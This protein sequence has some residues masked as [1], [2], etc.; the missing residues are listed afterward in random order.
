M[1]NPEKATELVS[2]VLLKGEV[3][4]G[5]STGGPLENLS[6]QLW[7]REVLSL[8]QSSFLPFGIEPLITEL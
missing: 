1:Q 3:V 4:E 2:Q 8:V 6:E 5:P 7:Q